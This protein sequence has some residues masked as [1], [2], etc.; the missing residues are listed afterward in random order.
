MDRVDAAGGPGRRAVRRDIPGDVVDRAGCARRRG[1]VRDIY[2]LGDD[3]L[4]IVAT[5]RISAFD[6][7]LPTAIPDKGRVLTGLERLLVR[8]ARVVPQPPDLDRDR[9]R[10]PRPPRRRDR[11]ALGGPLDDRAEGR[12]RPVRM[13][14]PGLPLGQ[15]LARVSRRR[16]GLRHRAARRAWSRATD[17]RLDP[18]AAWDRRSSRRPPRPSRGTTRTSRSPGWPRRSATVAAKLLAVVERGDL[19][20]GRGLRRVARPDP[21]R[22]QVRVGL[23]PPD[24]RAA[25]GRRGADP[26]QLAILAEGR[27][28]ARAA[29][30]PRSTSSSSATG[31]RRPAGTR[32][33]RPRPCPTTWSPGPARSTSRR[34]RS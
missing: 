17:P 14:R 6:W 32:R 11:E 9:R 22:H 29:R 15:R 8:A 25:P 12:G 7:V 30:S 5:D 18:R 24:R 28:L 33:A 16:H 20:P 13:R 2:D 10:G 1:K 19:P 26:R 34:T 23:G 4:L 3:R 21:G 27:L 31:S